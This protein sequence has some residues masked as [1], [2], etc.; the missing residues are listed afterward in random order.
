MH[1]DSRD[2]SISSRS[3]SPTWLG[4]ARQA[5]EQLAIAARALVRAEGLAAELA[6]D[7]SAP[8]PAPVPVVSAE[9]I[10]TLKLELAKLEKSASS[11]SQGALSKG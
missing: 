2:S 8:A 11:A 7:I 1:E 3:A 4:V 6:A 10:T 5:S 9:R